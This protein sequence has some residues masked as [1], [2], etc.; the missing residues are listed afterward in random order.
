M[1][2]GIYDYATTTP[3][4][5]GAANTDA[6]LFNR[7]I[8]SGGVADGNCLRLR[9]EFDGAGTADF[10]LGGVSLLIDPWPISG[11]D[12]L[13]E[14]EVWRTGRYTAM[15]RPWV[16]NGGG[17]AALVPGGRFPVSGLDWQSGQALTVV[18]KSTTNGGLTLDRAGLMR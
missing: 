18:G 2:N 17:N 14:V 12:V 1:A 15:A 10:Q 3:V 7:N 11:S 4:S 6:T 5:T 9:C 16:G 8:A 13:I